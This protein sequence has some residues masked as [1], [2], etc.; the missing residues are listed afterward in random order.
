MR[1]DNL[2]VPL[3]SLHSALLAL[4][5]NNVEAMLEPTKRTGR[6]PSSPS[7]YVL[8]GIAVGASLRLESTGLSTKDA[9]KEVAEKLNALGIK[10]AR[11]IKPAPGENGVTAGTLRRWRGR[12]SETRPLLRSLSLSQL[13]LSDI[14]AEDM[15][16]INAATIADE[17]V[18]E[19]ERA[20][21]A[22]LTPAEAQRIVLAFLD[23]SV[24]EIALADPAKPPS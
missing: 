12:I 19:E 14:S 3:L 7:R 17:M 13:K 2:H 23:A 4:D 15:G 22:A 1:A 21:L 6:A 10:P 9:N 20:K 24:R 11:G 8:I 16:W 5:E 18:T